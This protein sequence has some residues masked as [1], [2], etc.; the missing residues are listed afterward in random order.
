MFSSFAVCFLWLVIYLD[1]PM[2]FIRTAYTVQDE[3]YLQELGDLT[4]GRTAEENLS[5][6]PNDH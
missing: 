5:H 4:N 3:G 2:G 6:F 1:D